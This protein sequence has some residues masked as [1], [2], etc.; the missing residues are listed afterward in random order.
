MPYQSF[1]ASRI[2]RVLSAA[3]GESRAGQADGGF[4]AA[5]GLDWR[6]VSSGCGLEDLSAEPNT[7]AG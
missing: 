5:G 2:F 6:C 7:Y 1:R 4:L 3:L